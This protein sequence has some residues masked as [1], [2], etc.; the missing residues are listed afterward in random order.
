MVLTF[1]SCNRNPL[2]DKIDNRFL[3]FGNCF[4]KLNQA[5]GRFRED[6]YY[7]LNIFPIHIPP[8]RER[9]VDIPLLV[10]YFVKKYAAKIDR[11]VQKVS[12]E[13]MDS[14]QNCN[15]PGNV[16]F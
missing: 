14:L 4:V 1:S 16:I 5:E 8:L 15:W 10:R 2:C 11:Q 9:K 6:L 13:V 7:R 3:S 12:Q